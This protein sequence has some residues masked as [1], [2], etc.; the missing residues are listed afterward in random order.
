MWAECANMSMDQENVYVTKNKAISAEE[1]FYNKEVTGWQYM[2]QFGKI[3]IINCRS[4]NKHKAKHL[5]PGRPC[6]Y[7]GL[8][9]DR[10]RKGYLRLLNLETHK[11]IMSRDVIWM[12]V[13]YGDYKK[14][15]ELDVAQIAE[16]DDDDSNTEVDEV[17]LAGTPRKMLESVIFGTLF[18]ENVSCQIP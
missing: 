12:D 6:M 1:Q 11:V 3:G 13:R 8:A 2:R 16:V 9:K 10:W 4:E 7:L 18:L 17:N 5:N 14:L 15:P